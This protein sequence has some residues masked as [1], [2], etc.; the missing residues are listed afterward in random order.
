MII[1]SK[2]Q[3]A[4]PPLILALVKVKLV[5]IGETSTFT[6]AWAARVVKADELKGTWLLDSKE[7]KRRDQEP[8]DSSKKLV[9]SPLRPID[10]LR[11]ELCDD[12][13]KR[14]SVFASHL[15]AR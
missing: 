11:V 5:R 15:F 3:S 4:A 7:S 12:E 14:I 2:V 8:V 6:L 13:L 1:A 10:D 9:E